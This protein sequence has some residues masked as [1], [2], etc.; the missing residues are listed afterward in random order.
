[1]DTELVNLIDE[2]NKSEPATKGE[3]ISVEEKIDSLETAVN[4][5]ITEVKELVNNFAGVERLKG[6]KGD[7]GEPGESIVGP[8]G[9]KGDSVIGP[10]GIPGID[11]KNGE[12]ST[13][14]GPVGEKGEPGKDGRDGSPDFSE[15]IRNKL[16]L[17]DG[18][19]RLKIDAIKDLREELTKL[20][21]EAS[22]KVIGGGG[23]VIGRDFIKDIDL[24]SQLDGVTKTFNL[25]AVWN[26]I[27]VY[28]SSF[29]HALRKTVDWTWTPTSITFTD[30][31]DAGSTLQSGQTLILTVVSG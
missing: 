12:N 29:P 11:G 25:P 15:D 16:E 1:M 18:D 3:L 31:I 30:E 28:G 10:Q 27:A 26:I 4:K 8:K 23:T 21:K 24:S 5:D 6:E 9:E 20:R 13:I 2:L 19:E 22:T 7:K 17:L 14:P